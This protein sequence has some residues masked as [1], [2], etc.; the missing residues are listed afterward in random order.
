[1]NNSIPS[2]EA[3]PEKQ[4]PSGSL[5]LASSS[6]LPCTDENWKEIIRR[7]ADGRPICNCGHSYYTA[8]GYAH[9]RDES[10]PKGYR[11]IFDDL[12]CDGGC[13]TAQLAA[14][15]YVAMRTLADFANFSD[16]P[17]ARG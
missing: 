1:M 11:E 12:V 9:I 2:G 10:D 6:R 4:A 5:G 16:Q 8:C 14:K 7:C 13:S 15:E 3:T 17:P